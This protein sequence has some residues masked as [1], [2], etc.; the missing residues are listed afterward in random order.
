[1]QNNNYDHLFEETNA[2]KLLRDKRAQL[3]LTFLK[4]VFGDGQHSV[5]QDELIR[6]LTDY[7]PLYQDDYVFDDLDQKEPHM[8][9]DSI[10]KY[11]NKAKSLI[12]EWENTQKRYLRGDNNTEGVYEY[13]LTEHV[14]RAWQ[15]LEGLQKRDFTGTRSRLNDIF[16]KLNRVVENSREKTDQDRIDAIE[17][18]K[19]ALEQEI[20]LIRA[21]K[22]IYK[23]LNKLELAE[24]YMYLQEQVLALS[25]DFKSVEGRFERIRNEILIRQALSDESKGHLLQQALDARDDLDSTPQGMSFNAFFEDLSNKQRQ[26]DYENQM[27]NLFELLAQHGIETENDAPLRR[28]Y[29][30]LMSEAQPV[31][32]ANRRIVDRIRWFVGEQNRQKRQLLRQRLTEVKTAFLDTEVQK[33]FKH[34]QN[35]WEIDSAVCEIGLPLEKSLKIEMEDRASKY[36]SP[37][38]NTLAKPDIMIEDDGFLGELLQLRVTEALADSPNIS[39]GELVK[40]HP[41]TDGIAELIAYLN[42]VGL[43]QQHQISGSETEKFI[44][45]APDNIFVDGPK[46]EFRK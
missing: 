39:L 19:L 26:L 5:S 8:E 33:Q 6:R 14:V 3:I 12:R 31:L 21:G 43:G 15:W 38:E 45:S 35:I 46:A 2:L 40:T 22:S 17:A 34:A 28:L 44:L 1:M 27:A 7:L 11:R 9:A 42:L 16:E 30:H 13:T 4:T 41:M 25:T 32:E 23:P 18:K 10:D 24:E 36:A 29:K 20:E 37:T